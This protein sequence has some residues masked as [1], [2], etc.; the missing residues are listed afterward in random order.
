MVTRENHGSLWLFSFLYILPSLSA[1]STPL[2]NPSQPMY[3]RT[4][5]QL[6]MKLQ[7]VPSIESLIYNATFIAYYLLSKCVFWT[8]AFKKNR[9]VTYKDT[10]SHVPMP[11]YCNWCL[12]TAHEKIQESSIYITVNS[13]ELKSKRTYNSEVH[14]ESFQ[15]FV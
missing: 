10:F 11:P 7:K 13:E 3:M 6:K 1:V 9:P 4:M 2:P 5:K 12:T 15:M 14:N 8:A